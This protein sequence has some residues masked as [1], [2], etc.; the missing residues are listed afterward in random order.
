MKRISTQ[1]V[2][3]LLLVVPLV[4]GT[5]I[6]FGQD[7][8]HYTLHLTNSSACDIYQI[9]LSSSEGPGWYRKLL[10]DDI[11]TSSGSI[12]ILNIVPGEY[13]LKLVDEDRGAC[14]KMNV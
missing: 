12:D 5:G 11:L 1:V 3:I 6:V 2:S 7:S 14:V 8:D 13:D 4:G 9:Y 10:G